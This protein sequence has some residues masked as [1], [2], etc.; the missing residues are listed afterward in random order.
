MYS[1]PAC[2]DFQSFTLLTI[3]PDVQFLRIDGF[4]VVTPVNH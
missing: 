1:F 4:P 3:N 2:M